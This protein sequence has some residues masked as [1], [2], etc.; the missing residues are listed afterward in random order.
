MGVC[1]GAA[2]WPDVP[3]EF[4]VDGAS[5]WAPPPLR[6]A[7]LPANGDDERL[8][9]SLSREAQVERRLRP[10]VPHA[11]VFFAGQ[12]GL[13][14][15]PLV[16]STHPRGARRSASF[17]GGKEITYEWDECVPKEER[18]IIYDIAYWKLLVPGLVVGFAIGFGQQVFER[19]RQ[20]RSEN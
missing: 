18:P 12:D 11:S 16:T 17:L 4:C 20:R 10:R 1:R 15:L 3:V 5:A 9:A 7:A 2:L 13:H 8:G 14:A 19:I 6:R